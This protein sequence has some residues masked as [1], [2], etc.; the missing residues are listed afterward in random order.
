MFIYMCIWIII[1]EALSQKAMN[2][3]QVT[4]NKYFKITNFQKK[5]T[6]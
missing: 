3:R 1:C 5:D 4:S 6:Y 2:L